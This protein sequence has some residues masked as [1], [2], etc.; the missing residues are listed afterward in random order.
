MVAQTQ[1]V[2]FLCNCCSTTLVHSLNHQICYSGTTCLAK[3]AEW[4]QNHCH[5]GSRVAVVAEW[6]HSGRH[7]DYPTLARE[8]Q[9]FRV[10]GKF[11]FQTL[12][13][14]D[15]PTNLANQVKVGHALD[16]SRS[17]QSRGSERAHQNNEPSWRS[18]RTDPRFSRQFWDD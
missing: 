12:E 13:L 5:G 8:L 3:E 15:T 1:K 10:W 14:T 9:G 17:I 11:V 16:Q 4:R 6:R 18:S 2:L 7:S